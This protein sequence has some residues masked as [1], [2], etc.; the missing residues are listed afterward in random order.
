[1][2]P[3][4]YFTNIKIQQIGNSEPSRWEI[5]LEEKDA[6]RFALSSSGSGLK[7]ILLTLINLHLIP[8]LKEYKNK[9]IIYAFEELENNLHPAVQ[10]KL[11]DYLY[12]YAIEKD[13]TIFVTSHSNVPINT[14]YQKEHTRIYHVTKKNNT[15][16]FYEVEND[17]DNRNILEDL[18]VKA[19]DLLQTNGIIWVEGPSDRV[20]INRWLEVFC[21]SKFK[22][23]TDYQ[24]L[25]YGGRLLSHYTTE[26]DTDDL[27]NVLF[28]NRNAAIVIDSDYKTPSSR[29]NSTKKRI[30]EEFQKHNYLCWITKGKEI[31]NYLS[32][33][34][35]NAKFNISL[36][37]IEKHTL[38]PDYIKPYEKS[39][40]RS[41]V[42]FAHKIAPYITSQNSENIL[43][44]KKMTEK[45]YQ[46]IQ[47]WNS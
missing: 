35:I 45:L 36:K 33:G 4:S 41:K 5:F 29:I 38:F 42:D 10:R 8:E 16:S 24:F 2:S 3:D 14:Y 9:K 20:Y 40:E 26:T 44:L 30:K 25:Y 12:S 13:T 28:T 21:N 15:S 19:S 22:E 37:Q 18:D 27:I 32:A 31:E 17:N 34:A 1:M 6:G 23:G 39:F 7:T 43:D 11:F 47:K 46:E